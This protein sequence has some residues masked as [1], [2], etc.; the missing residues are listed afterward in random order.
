MTSV[1]L[2]AEVE[3]LGI[4]IEAE[5]DGL[6][7]R[8]RVDRLTD[9]LRERLK[10]SKAEVLRNLKRCTMPRI[11]DSGELVVPV[12]TPPRYRWWQGGQSVVDTLTELRA[13]PDVWKRYTDRPYPVS[14]KAHTLE[15]ESSHCQH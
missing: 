7:L 15:N 4:R 10:S 11:N 12:D 14:L 13:S 1:T 2:V 8:G 3:A 9:N 6:L 5:G